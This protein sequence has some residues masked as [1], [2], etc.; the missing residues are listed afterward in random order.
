MADEASFYRI[1]GGSDYDRLAL[2]FPF[3]VVDI[4]RRPDLCNGKVVMI[5]N[6]KLI[7][8]Q[9]NYIYGVFGSVQAFGKT[10]EGGWFVID[11]SAQ[12]KLVFSEKAAFEAFL[13]EHGVSNKGLLPVEPLIRAFMFKGELA[14][15]RL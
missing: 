11:S 1:R 6:V 5:E 9:S 15:P 3:H 2:R 14:F 12:T 7:N 8:M 4:T 10:R 13:I